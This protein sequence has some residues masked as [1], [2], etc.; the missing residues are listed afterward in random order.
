ML[1]DPALLLG[2][3]PFSLGGLAFLLGGLAFLLASQQHGPSP[4]GRV[5][6]QPVACSS[7]GSSQLLSS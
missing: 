3:P 5:V 1:G 2:D 7:P 6:L 4:K